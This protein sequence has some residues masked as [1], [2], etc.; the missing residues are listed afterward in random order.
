MLGRWSLDHTQQMINRKADM[1]NE[2]HCD[3]MSLDYIKDE[4]KSIDKQKIVNM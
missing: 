4:E 1:T 2:D 3:K